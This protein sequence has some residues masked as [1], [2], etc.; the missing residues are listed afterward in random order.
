[1]PRT[2]YVETHLD[3]G[4]IADDL[5]AIEPPKITLRQILERIRPQ[6]ELSRKR[7]ATYEQM[8]KTLKAH[9]IVASAR[10]IREFMEGTATKRSAAGADRRTADADTPLTAAALG[11]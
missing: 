6:L 1:M 5:G 9:G 2:E 7:G 10:A 8:S 11:E 4:A 3:F